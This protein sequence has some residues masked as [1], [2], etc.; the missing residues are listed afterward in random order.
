MSFMGLIKYLS[1]KFHEKY[2]ASTY[3]HMTDIQ[4]QADKAIRELLGDDFSL[5]EKKRDGGIIF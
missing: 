5:I 2:E 4:K 3:S 1:T